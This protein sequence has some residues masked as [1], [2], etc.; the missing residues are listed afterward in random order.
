MAKAVGDA[1]NAMDRAAL[2]APAPNIAT[3]AYV[4][5]LA[6]IAWAIMM[7]GNRNNSALAFTTIS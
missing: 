4:N 3:V 7:H 1:Q 6:R 5:N 2:G